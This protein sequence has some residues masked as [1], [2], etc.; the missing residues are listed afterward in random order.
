MLT[1]VYS[2]YD[3]LTPSFLSSL[4]LFEL[5]KKATDRHRSQ[6]RMCLFL[7]TRRSRERR[8]GNVIIFSVYYYFFFPMITEKHSREDDADS[9]RRL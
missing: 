3:T 5:L 9:T 1:A 4:S 7:Q 2:I 6:P 8:E